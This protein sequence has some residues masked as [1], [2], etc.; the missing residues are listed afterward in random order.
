MLAGA[1]EDRRQAAR[2]VGQPAAFGVARFVHREVGVHD[3]RWAD[4]GGRGGGVQ[5]GLGQH[6]QQA[7][8]AGE[9]GLAALVGAGEHQDAPAGGH[10][11]V[12]ADDGRGVLFA[13][14]E[15]EVDVVQPGHLQVPFAG[16]G[17]PRPAHRQAACPERA[18]QLRRA[19]IERDL[20]FQ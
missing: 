17:E 8:G 18:E 11:Q 16:A 9:G 6:L 12:I 5:T 7:D 14:A 19:Q 4:R 1:G 10:V 13:A 2:L 15:G 3:V 20:P